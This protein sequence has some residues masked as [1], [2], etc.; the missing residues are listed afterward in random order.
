[1]AQPG[2]LASKFPVFMG[3]NV[4]KKEKKVSYK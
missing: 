2:L 4:G 3:N 1:M